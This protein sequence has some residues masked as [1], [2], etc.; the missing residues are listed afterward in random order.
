MRLEGRAERGNHGRR[1][2]SIVELALM[3]PAI[4]LLIVGVIDL[5]RVYFSYVGIVNAAREGARYGALMPT[6]LTGIQYHVKQ[7]ASSLG[8]T[9]SNITKGCPN[10]SD[11]C[12]RGG[13]IKV[14]VTHAFHPIMTTI[15]GIETINL[16]ASAQMPVL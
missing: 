2:Q 6:D 1:G 9:N 13:P 16:R 15:L 11:T 14:T 10:P 8:L 4:L 3:L 5:G 7:E 12:A